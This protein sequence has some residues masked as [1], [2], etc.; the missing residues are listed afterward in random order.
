MAC[1]H[2]NTADVGV[3][4]MT[5][6][7]DVSQKIGGTSCLNAELTCA[8][9]VAAPGQR[10]NTIQST[11]HPEWLELRSLMPRQ[12]MLISLLQATCSQLER[13]VEFWITGGTL[14]GAIR[15]GG[16]IPHDDDVD[17][18][19]AEKDFP[20]LEAAFESHHLLN[21][22]K[23]GYWNTTPVAHVGIKGTDVELD[24]FLREEGL[25]L[26]RDFPC[27]TEIFPLCSYDFHGVAVPGPSNP[28]P[29]LE[30]LYGADWNDAVKVWS[31]NFN[32]YHGLAHDPERVRLTLSEYNSHVVA[33]GYTA[34]CTPSKDIEEALKALFEENGPAQ[35]LKKVSDETWLEKLRRRNREQAEAQLRL[36]ESRE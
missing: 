12:T 24:I 13:K 34:P 27:S 14:L 33:C 10:T 3:E 20:S 35:A 7:D 5:G 31:H 25:E 11:S 19:C 6:G 16:F 22:R 36:R 2:R 17:L 8:L 18:E 32:F 21:F 15:H 26:Q 4:Q 1:S 30:R 9:P 28:T 23:G 29:F